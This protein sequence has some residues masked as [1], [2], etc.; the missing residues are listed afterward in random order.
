MKNVYITVLLAKL[1][2]CVC[3]G[4][5]AMTSLCQNDAYKQNSNVERQWS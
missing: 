5:F 3:A 4:W 1:M 2:V